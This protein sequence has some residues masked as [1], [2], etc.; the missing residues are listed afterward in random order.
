VGDDLEAVLREA[1]SNAAR[2]ARARSVTV[3]VSAG[4][5]R[6]ALVVT[7]DGVG[8]GDTTR[9]SGLANLRQRAE[10][11]GGGCTVEPADPTGTRLR[12]HVPLP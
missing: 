6:L 9:R 12:W 4:D 11:H 1:L 7:D 10:R 2:H 5:S 8:M 3:D